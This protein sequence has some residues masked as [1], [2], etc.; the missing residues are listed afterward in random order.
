MQDH[1]L[2]YHGV[3]RQLSF[4]RPSLQGEALDKFTWRI[5]ALTPETLTMDRSTATAGLKTWLEAYAARILSEE[6][7]VDEAALE[8]R[9]KATNPRF[10]LRQWVLE[11]VISALEKDE[12]RGKHVLAKVMQMAERPFEAWGAEGTEE[13]EEGGVCINIGEE[14]REERRFCGM[15]AKSMLGFQCSCSS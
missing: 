7:Q 11:E 10:V 6:P 8:A 9:R 12:G 1:K 2:D 13:E 15:G 5:L 3:F 14:Q 4:F